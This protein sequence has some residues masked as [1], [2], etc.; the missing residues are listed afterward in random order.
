MIF[1]TLLKI[2]Y[3]ALQLSHR[4]RALL[5]LTAGM[6]GLMVPE[7]GLM[8]AAVAGQCGGYQQ[9]KQG[10]R[11]EKWSFDGLFCYLN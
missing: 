5:A 2:T 6:G 9:E 11:E 8:H 1:I 3:P 7:T 4:R 10:R